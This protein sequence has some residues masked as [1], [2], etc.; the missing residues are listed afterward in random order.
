[1][2]K[3]RWRILPAES[4]VAVEVEV[5]VGDV[6]SKQ[7]QAIMDLPMS[8]AEVCW[9]FSADERVVVAG[10]SCQMSDSPKW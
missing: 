7:W 1:M 9:T 5:V 2:G 8:V 10:W 6:V 4:W 3:R